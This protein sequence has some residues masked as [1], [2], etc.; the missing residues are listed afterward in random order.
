MAGWTATPT[1]TPLS[2]SRRCKTSE[3]LPARLSWHW[4]RYPRR[5]SFGFRRGVDSLGFN[6]QSALIMVRM[7]VK[8]PVRGLGSG[9]VIQKLACRFM[10]RVSITSP[11]LFI[12]AVG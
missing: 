3:G 2:A 1:D 9:Q 10:G 4:F 11:S 8:L 12:H 7:A 5:L 6:H